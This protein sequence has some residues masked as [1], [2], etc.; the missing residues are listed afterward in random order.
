MTQASAG[1]PAEMAALGEERLRELIKTIGLF[2]TKAETV[3]ARSQIMAARHGGVVPLSRE[4]L[5]ALPDEF[6][7]R[8]PLADPARPLLLCGAAAVVRT[9]PDQ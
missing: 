7:P 9:I 5:E 1:T 8:P 3:V 6:R 4:A 2:R